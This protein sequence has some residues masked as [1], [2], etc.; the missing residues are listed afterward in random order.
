VL[1]DDKE[2]VDRDDVDCDNVGD[3]EDDVTGGG[4]GARVLLV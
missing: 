2:D 3:G 1:Q 4:G